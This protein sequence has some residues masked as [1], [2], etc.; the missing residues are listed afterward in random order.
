MFYLFIYLFL[1]LFR[2]VL[3]V[4]GKE[5]EKGDVEDDL[6]NFLFE[7][8]NL[9]EVWTVNETFLSKSKLYDPRHRAT[10]C[11]IILKIEI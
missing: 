6:W 4:L 9:Y 5:R 2:S 3:L 1:S 7:L 8:S 11:F 10:K